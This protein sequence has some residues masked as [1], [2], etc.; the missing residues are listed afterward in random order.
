M[1]NEVKTL[2]LELATYLPESKH[3]ILEFLMTRPDPESLQKFLRSLT[4]EETQSIET[5][6]YLM[7]HIELDYVKD[8]N[9]ANQ[10]LESI[11]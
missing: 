7:T 10:M 2:Y 1:D 5:M 11:L 9:M 6:Y 4:E 3:E 8:T